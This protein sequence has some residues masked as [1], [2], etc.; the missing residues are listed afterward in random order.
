MRHQYQRRRRH[1][2]QLVGEVEEEVEVEEEGGGGG[3]QASAWVHDETFD[4]STFN[5]PS[6]EQTFG[7][8]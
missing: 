3:E 8:K 4:E 1:R 5:S 7:S 2:R 6:N